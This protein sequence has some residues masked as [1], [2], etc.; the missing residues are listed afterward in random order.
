MQSQ[1]SS[2]DSSAFGSLASLAGVGFSSYGSKSG[3]IARETILSRDFFQHIISFEGVLP[4]LMAAKKFDSASNAI[5]FDSAIYD[6]DS[7]TWTSGV[8]HY[9]DGY[10]IYSQIIRVNL[11]RRTNF[12]VLSATHISPIFAADLVSLIL[13]EI[14]LLQRERDIVESQSSLEYL[15]EQFD[16]TMDIDIKLSINQMIEGQLKTQMLAKVRTHYILQPIDAAFI[17]RDKTS[18]SRL[19]IVIFTTVVGF[20][21]GIILLVARHFFYPSQIRKT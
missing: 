6:P 7:K 21:I 1:S 3:E 9:L 12:V 20:F 10:K 4:K 11:D 14:N 2:A 18:P 17:P 15:Y 8:P 16:N 19:R 5:V 13:R